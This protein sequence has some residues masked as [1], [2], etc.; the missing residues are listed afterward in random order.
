VHL[1][2]EAGE[3]QAVVDEAGNGFLLTGELPA[4]AGGNVY[5]LWGKVDDQVLSL[6]TFGGDTSVVPFSL[7]ARKVGDVQAFMVTEEAFP[8]VASSK[9][10]AVVI[11]EA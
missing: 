10:P 4:P 8:G 2:G 3:A 11:G 7:D 1:E 6:G 5:Q 9:Q